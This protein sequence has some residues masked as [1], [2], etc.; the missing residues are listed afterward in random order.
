MPDG[1]RIT[2]EYKLTGK[3]ADKFFKGS[4]PDCVIEAAKAYFDEL[5]GEDKYRWA[6]FERIDNNTTEEYIGT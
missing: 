5:L 4:S 2:V 1:Y 6:K 3:H